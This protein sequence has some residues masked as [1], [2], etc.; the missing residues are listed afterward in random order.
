MALD[1]LYSFYPLNNKLTPRIANIPLIV[2]TK[3][4]RAHV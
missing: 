3:I 1:N 2:K 4:G